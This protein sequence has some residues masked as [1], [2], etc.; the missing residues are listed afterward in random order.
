MWLPAA[1]PQCA[2][3]W[4]ASCAHNISAIESTS[5]TCPPESCCCS[6]GAF[7]IENT[8][9]S[10]APWACAHWGCLNEISYTRSISERQTVTCN[11]GTPAMAQVA[12][13]C[14]PPFSKRGN[15]SGVCL[16]CSFAASN[17]LHPSCS[18]PDSLCLGACIPA[19]PYIGLVRHSGPAQAHVHKSSWA[20]T[21]CC[22]THLGKQPASHSAVPARHVTRPETGN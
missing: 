18:Q 15:A 1:L 19:V 16:P 3:V 12:S 13:S 2:Y 21:S 6:R 22:P 11:V 8:D 9:V 17:L 4:H 5:H 14:V 7:V 20:L 10:P